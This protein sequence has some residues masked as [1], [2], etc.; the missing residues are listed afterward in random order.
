MDLQNEPAQATWGSGNPNND[1]DLGAAEIGNALL[2][3]RKVTRAT[4]V[5]ADLVAQEEIVS[6][7]QLNDI[8]Q[9]ADEI[10]QPF[11]TT[12]SI[13]LSSEG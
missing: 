1:W 5:I 12:A 9:A 10:M 13:V 2:I 6:T 4:Q 7:A 3:D 11:P 8:M